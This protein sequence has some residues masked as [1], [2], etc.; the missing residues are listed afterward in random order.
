MQHTP[1]TAVD[2]AI[3]ELRCG[4]PV[5]LGNILV[6]SF[7]SMILPLPQ[8]SQLI[9]TRE[10]LKYL[11]VVTQAA[12]Q[13]YAAAELTPVQQ[14]ALL[15][16]AGDL[17]MVKPVESPSEAASALHLLKLARLI[18]VAVCIAAEED[19]H[20]LWVKAEEIA[21]YDRAR[22]ETL[23][24][25]AAAALPLA[26]LENSSARVFRAIDG[27]EHLALTIG[28][29]ATEKPPL[30]RVHSSC[31]TG[32]VLGSL[33]CD[34]GNQLHA[35]LDVMAREGY[36]ILCYLNQEGRGIGIANKM[37][38]YALQDQGMD[39]L[40]ANECLGF[41]ADERQFGLAAAMLKAVGVQNIRLLT[42]NP[43]KVASLEQ[44]GITVAE[45]VPLVAPSNSHNAGYLQTKA[46]RFGHLF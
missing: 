10:K 11:G 34:C 45:R 35:A 33:R 19:N 24:E 18:P 26:H 41:A 21:I 4:R 17:G 38:A 15:G 37:R 42:N 3:Y 25:I 16:N 7:E 5:R 8:A 29:A 12:Y 6:S 36:G 23:T 31:L 9:V 2:R 27:T 1:F 30:V 13:A 44:L 43:A 32:D 46:R 22:Q 39:T 40:E 28:N 20:W 14:Q